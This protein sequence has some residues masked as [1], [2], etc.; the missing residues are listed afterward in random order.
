MNRKQA[1]KKLVDGDWVIDG[2]GH[3]M[4]MSDEGLIYTETGGRV[5]ALVESQEPFELYTRPEEDEIEMLNVAENATYSIPA[6]FY[7]KDI[8]IKVKEKK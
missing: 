8:K 5:S 2:T 1:L 3:P 6:K 7:G 4:Y